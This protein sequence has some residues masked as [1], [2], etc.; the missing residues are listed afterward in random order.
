MYIGTYFFHHSSC[1]VAGTPGAKN[2]F[3][4]EAEMTLLTLARPWN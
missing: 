2:S 3:V 4:A 1:S